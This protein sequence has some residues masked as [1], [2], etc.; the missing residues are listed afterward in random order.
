MN[1]CPG[2]TRFQLT[3]AIELG[4]IC[5]MWWLV[6]WSAPGHRLTHYK[7][8]KKRTSMVIELNTLNFGLK[9]LLKMSLAGL[10]V[11]NLNSLICINISKLSTRKQGMIFNYCH[12]W[13]IALGLQAFNS[14]RLSNWAFFV[15]CGG[16]SRARRQAISSLIINPW[17]RSL[18]N[19]ESNTSNLVWKYCC[20]CR[21]PPSLC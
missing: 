14:L 3:E 18:L 7:S 15:W 10:T 8:L 21:L 9:M 20:K 4:F 17:K 16:L 1:Y 19:I 5:L 12:R 2:N 6:A 11:L 13:I